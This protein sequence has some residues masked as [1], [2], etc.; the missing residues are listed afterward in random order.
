MADEESRCY[1]GSL[2]ELPDGPLEEGLAQ[3][4]GECPEC[5]AL[6][7]VT[8]EGATLR[9]NRD[10]GR[11]KPKRRARARPERPL[12]SVNLVGNDLAGE[13]VLELVAEAPS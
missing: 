5:E 11:F 7:T 4:L 8:A 13:L 2:L 6:H 3:V 9:E 1:C 10:V 12:D